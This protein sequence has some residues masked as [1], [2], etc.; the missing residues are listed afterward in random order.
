MFGRA[1][2]VSAV[3]GGSLAA[4]AQ[5]A[6]ATP[7]TLYV[8]TS[9]TNTANNCRTALNPCKTISYALTQAAGFEV[10][11]VQAGTYPEQVTITD[12][13]VT[14]IGAGKTKTII[15]PTTLT[16]SD[17]DSDSTQV[18]YPIVD[19]KS[20]GVNLTNLGV[21][22]SQASSFFT[23][24]SLDYVGVYYHDATGTMSGDA[25][26]GVELP[27]SLFGCQDGLAV[28][29]V[30]D[31]SPNTGNTLLTIKTS[32]VNTYDKNGITC[33]DP[34]TVC[35]ISHTTVTGIGPTPLIAQNGIQIG[36]AAGT[37]SYDTVS[38]NSYT[39]NGT[40]GTGI[41]IINPYTFKMNNNVVSAN[42]DNVYVLQQ[43]TNP[44]WQ[45]CGAPGTPTCTNTAKNATVFTIIN[46][47]ASNGTNP[48]ANAPGQGY[49]DGIDLDS[50]IQATTVSGNTAN[51]D[52]G[53]G[54]SLFGSAG[55]SL[56]NN[57]GTADGDGYYLGAGFVTAAPATG[58]SVLSN[59]AASS[60]VDGS[61]ADATSSGNIIKSNALSLSG[62]F[63]AADASTGTGTAGT[64][65]TYHTNNCTTSNPPGLCHT[66]KTLGASSGLSSTARSTKATVKPAR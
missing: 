5:V 6:S 40:T 62:A 14:I 26:T 32:V 56:H 19:V 37:L 46:N 31:G 60:T 1:V 9:G 35:N 49:G 38:G 61:F 22:G 10:I 20:T 53:N 47:T 41:L 63:D 3:I 21:D 24:C 29:A 17:T 50:V 11:K 43:L 59:S 34:G 8:S 18:Q 13:S 55:V 45:Y 42:D 12:P 4:T 36:G 65:N 2:I 44:F 16:T 33:D 15:Q 66:L 52:S 7:L 39:P 27:P 64:N 54:F 28:Y 58:N 51:A 48:N 25:V 57:H 23:S 30:T